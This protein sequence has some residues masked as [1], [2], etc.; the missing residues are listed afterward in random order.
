M[1]TYS[2]PLKD[3]KFVLKELAGLEQVAIPGVGPVCELPAVQTKFGT[4]RM[5]AGEG[6][7]TDI[8]KCQL[9]P[10]RQ[11]DFYP[12]TF[13]ADQRV[14]VVHDPIGNLLTQGRRIHGRRIDLH[15]QG[16]IA[17]GRGEDEHL[18]TDQPSLLE[19]TA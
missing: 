14:K 7:A 2:A 13:T 12:V 10:L 1:S 17:V 8:E 5:Q 16:Q 6:L 3:M 18:A 11:A 15:T 9:K 19:S 4:P